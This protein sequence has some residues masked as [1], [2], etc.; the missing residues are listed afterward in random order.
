VVALLEEHLAS[1]RSISPPE[2][3]HALDI[4]SL[5]A[6][7][8]AFFTA[9]DRG[10][11]LGCGAL[12]DLGHGHGEIKSMRTAASHLRK[13]VATALLARLLEHAGARGMGRVSLETGAQDEFA[14]ARA[15][16]GRFGFLRCGPFGT[17]TDDPNSVFMSR[18]LNA[19]PR[20]A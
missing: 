5:C 16:Y 12:A 4:E 8:I 11:L 3:K 14:P 19:D 2:S 13:G 1:M 10:E 18:S 7:H 9:R 15:L 17:Y 20:E 6:P